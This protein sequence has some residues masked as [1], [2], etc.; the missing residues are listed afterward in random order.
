MNEK[1]ISTDFKVYLKS[2]DP[3]N[4]FYWIPW[5]L[6]PNS[7]SEPARMARAF[8]HPKPI[9]Y[10]S[11]FD[12]QQ[13]CY[14]AAYKTQLTFFKV[15]NSFCLSFE[16]SE[17]HWSQCSRTPTRR[18]FEK[19]CDSVLQNC[20]KSIRLRLVLF[21]YLLLMTVIF[22][23]VCD[24]EVFLKIWRQAHPNKLWVDLVG[25]YLYVDEFYDMP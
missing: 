18:Q 6:A 16:H 14:I 4:W 12:R 25:P 8:A 22:W 21:T 24:T 2:L 10:R 19:L 7:N 5:Y 9:N 3:R 20:V 1:Y 23:Q 17:M 15:R 13:S 11:Y